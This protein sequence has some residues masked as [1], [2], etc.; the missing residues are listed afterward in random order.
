MT[1][2]DSCRGCI[3]YRF[4]SWDKG[5]K[6]CHYMLDTGKKRNCPAD[7]CD[8]H[9][10]DAEIR[11]IQRDKSKKVK[12]YSRPNELL[13]SAMRGSKTT[14]VKLSEFLGITQVTFSRKLNRAL[15]QGYVVKFTK[16]EKAKIAK[17][18]NFPS[19]MIE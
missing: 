4:F 15:V 19:T 18:L 17:A 3:Y 2:R 7:N 1:G 8:K 14:G 5:N 10:T 9:C 6:G 11:R 16:E 12:L 13:R